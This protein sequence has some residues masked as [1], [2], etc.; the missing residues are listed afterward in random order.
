MNRDEFVEN[1]QLTGGYFLAINDKEYEIQGDK[2]V[3]FPDGKCHLFKTWD[4]VF[5]VKADDKTLG[6]LVDD[7]KQYDKSVIYHVPLRIFDDDGNL[8]CN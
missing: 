1:L 2:V 8:M 4:E 7:L 5:A 6:E 3:V